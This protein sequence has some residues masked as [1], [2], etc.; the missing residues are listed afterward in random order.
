MTVG[1]SNP[2]TTKECT[3]FLWLLDSGTA[4]TFNQVTPISREDWNPNTSYNANDIVEYDESFYISQVSG[5]LNRPP[6]YGQPWLLLATD[7]SNT[8][9]I[10]NAPGTAFGGAP[11]D[12]PVTGDWSGFGITR[13]GVFRASAPGTPNFLWVL[14]NALPLTGQ[15]QHVVRTTYAYGGVAGDKPITG[16]W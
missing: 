8:H 16:H 15:D 6:V 3:P 4:G 5:N 14:D 11:G 2:P 10:G 9:M 1:C 12:I 7:A 13:F